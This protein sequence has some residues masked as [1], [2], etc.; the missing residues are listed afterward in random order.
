MDAAEVIAHYLARYAEPIVSVAERVEGSFGAVVV[1]PARR[2]RVSLVDGLR[3]ALVRQGALAIVVVN[4]AQGAS[5]DARGQADTLR[6][7]L[8]GLG[9]AR[10]VGDGV[11]QVSGRGLWGTTSWLVVDAASP[12]RALPVGAGVGR[13]RKLGCDLALAL[14]A[15]GRLRTEF[16]DTTDADAHLPED[17]FD[18]RERDAVALTRRFWHVPGRDDA[19]SQATALYELRLRLYVLG[20]SVAGS[21]WAFHTVGS[22]LSVRMDAYAAVRG[23]P[24]RAAGE[25]FYLLSKVAKLGAVAR[26]LGRPLLLASRDSDRVP[27]GTGPGARAIAE[28]VARGEVASAYAPRSFA[29]LRAVILGLEEFA[30]DPERDPV[31]AMLDAAR[32]QLS[33]PDQQ[34][35]AAALEDLAPASPL[36]RAI[37]GAK[38]PPARRRRVHEWFD[39]FRTLKL[40]HR[41]RAH[42]HEE[43]PW[44]QVAS[45][46][47]EAAP[48]GSPPK[49]D[50]VLPWRRHL[51]ATEAALARGGL[52]APS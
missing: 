13:A 39:A 46:L 51:L 27:F 30:R 31:A 33:A 6:G 44:P 41:L 14:M 1:V 26:G 24:S 49:S 2:E 23:M 7:A 35:L 40:I 8:C 22:T 38:T 9:D 43:E 25:D 11:V 28:A 36:R 10:D 21:P 50:E 4:E 29:A 42:G 5:E 34:I 17:Y 18:D 32:G 52:L 45:A 15:H 3:P 19:L 48:T 12:S 20:L 16:I 37:Q 47:A